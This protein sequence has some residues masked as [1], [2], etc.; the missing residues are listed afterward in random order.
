MITQISISYFT[1]APPITV[2]I[3]AGFAKHCH[4]AF[5]FVSTDGTVKK[6]INNKQRETGYENK[7]LLARFLTLCMVLSLLPL[8]EMTALAESNEDDGGGDTSIVVVK[9]DEDQPVVVDP[10]DGNVQI[11][12]DLPE[13]FQII[14]TM[15]YPW[16]G[17]GTTR[18][19]FLIEDAE[20]L[21]LLAEGVQQLEGVAKARYR[22]ANDI[23]LS[24]V[25]GPDVG[26]WL[27]IGSDDHPFC[28]VFDGASHT[29]SGLY[30]TGSGSGHALFGTSCG[31]VLN[32]TVDGTVSGSKYVA[33]IVAKN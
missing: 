19:P 18:D 21:K 16:H 2:R 20:D 24:S 23:D 27:P 22:L 8:A 5:F 14:V 17:G 11:D 10:E 25:C 15:D 28:G 1:S 7:R 9:P 12:V 29:I 26:N 30:L 31:F 3:Y 32:L 6:Q 33:G 4:L 13:D